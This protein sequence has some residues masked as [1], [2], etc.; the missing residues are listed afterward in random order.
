MPLPRY[1]LREIAELQE[2]LWLDSAWTGYAQDSELVRQDPF[3]A[4]ASAQTFEAGIKSAPGDVERL[5]RALS[6]NEEFAG[7]LPKSLVTVLAEDEYG[8]IA[9]DAVEEYGNVLQLATA[10]QSYI[11]ESTPESLELLERDLQSLFAGRVSRG[12]FGER[13]LCGMA[14]VSMAAGLATVWIP[15]HAHAVPAVVLGGIVYKKA[16]C[17]ELREA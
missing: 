1:I 5:V 6:D 16:G 7:P 15:P 10:G 8:H 13:F 14:M 3:G 11:I 2:L 4:I 17:R 9:L 12:Y